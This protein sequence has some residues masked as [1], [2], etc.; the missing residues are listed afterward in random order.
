[1]VPDLAGNGYHAC[2]LV[3]GVRVCVHAMVARNLILEYVFP[4]PSLLLY[5]EVVLLL[6]L[7]VPLPAAGFN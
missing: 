2:F 6:L 5:V 7:P 1:M 4:L 3:S